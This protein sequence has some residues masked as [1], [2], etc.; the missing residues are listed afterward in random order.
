MILAS[1]PEISEGISI[2]FTLPKKFSIQN[3]Q[4][5]DPMKSEIG[6]VAGW[7]MVKPVPP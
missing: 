4:T 1:T 3:S 5:E 2:V 6:E 7:I